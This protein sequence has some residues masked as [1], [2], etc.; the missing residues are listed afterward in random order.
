MSDPDLSLLIA[1]VVIAVI[2]AWAGYWH[3]FELTAEQAIANKTKMVSQLPEPFKS[4]Y[5]SRYGKPS[6]APAISRIFGFFALLI[7]ASIV[8][9]DAAH[10]L[11]PHSMPIRREFPRGSGAGQ[12]AIVWIQI[13]DGTFTMGYQ[14][15]DVYVY[16][17][18]RP[19]HRV[20]IKSFQMTKDL[21]TNRQYKA[22]VDAGACTAIPPYWS[23]AGDDEQPVRHADWNQAELFANWVGGRL[24][25]EAEWEYAARRTAKEWKSSPEW[26]QDWYHP[27][28]YGA[29]TNGSA[30][31]NPATT[32][33]AVRGGALS[34]TGVGSFRL[35]DRSFIDPGDINRGIGFRLAR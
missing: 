13:P 2:L 24:L 7:A 29:P 14:G 31:E 6:S 11:V 32:L 26:T 23:T 30:W 17:D 9:I 20:T 22:C 19:P 18:A 27:S 10:L 3:L 1:H 15:T 8:L 21:V 33:K 25:S 16:N 4:Y 34:A 12:V 35:E 5:I 28:Y